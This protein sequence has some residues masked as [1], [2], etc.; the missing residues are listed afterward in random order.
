MSRQSEKRLEHMAGVAMR[1]QAMSGALLALRARHRPSAK[2]A[3][4]PSILR[5]DAAGQRSGP[6]SSKKGGREV[7]SSTRQTENLK[8]V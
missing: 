4:P 8:A 7:V 3:K 6:L 1:R 5:D 2:S